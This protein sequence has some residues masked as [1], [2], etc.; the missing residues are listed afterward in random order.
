[1]RLSLSTLISNAIILINLNSMSFHLA[2][3]IQWLL[4]K[5]LHSQ[6][7]CEKSACYQY[8]YLFIQS[9]YFLSKSYGRKDLLPAR[10]LN[11]VA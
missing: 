8:V 6:Q 10:L 7:R 4:A 9:K 1:M 11:P 2:R 3:K 5:S